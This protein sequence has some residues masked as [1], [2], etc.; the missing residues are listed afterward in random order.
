[1][2]QSKVG[3]VCDSTADF[4]PGM[5]QELG[6]HIL[7][8]HI[9]VDGQDHLHGV[10][11]TNREVIQALKQRREVHTKPFYPHECADFFEDLLGRYEH[12]VSLH[13]STELSGNYLSATR[14]TQLMFDEDAAR[15][16]V[17]DL[18]GVSV[19][20]G[21]AVRKAAEL[22]QGDPN[23]D[24]LETRLRPCVDNLFMGFTVE[25]LVYLRKGGRVGALSAFLGGMLDI[26][27]IIQLERAR[28]V[29]KEKMRGKKSALKRLVEI[30]EAQ[31]RR[32]SGACHIWLAYADNVTEALETR[33]LLADRILRRPEDIH[34][35]EVGA[36]ISVHTGPGAV[37]IGMSPA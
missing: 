13:L 35:V 33:E 21:L 3:L 12:V 37:C 2:Q 31:Y 25:D 29:P 24:T 8:V 14:A 28:L 1:M 34:M 36:T 18:K 11:I 9:M 7:P 6:L 20:L 10:S 15:V 17:L 27:P 4:P 30:A 5:A 26:K 32:L 16:R 22:L 23:P 19:S